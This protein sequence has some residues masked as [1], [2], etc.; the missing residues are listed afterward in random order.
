[1]FNPLHS[2]VKFCELIRYPEPEYGSR[3]SCMVLTTSLSRWYN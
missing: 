3:R 1:M 2:Q